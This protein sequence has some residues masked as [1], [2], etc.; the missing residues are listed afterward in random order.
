MLSGDQWTTFWLMWEKNYIL[1][2]EGALPE[3][4]TLLKWRMDKKVKVEHI[5]FASTWGTNAQFR[6]FFYLFVNIFP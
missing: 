1:F 6:F 2:G 3:N 4:N 5:G